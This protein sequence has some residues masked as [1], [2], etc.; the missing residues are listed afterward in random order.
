M[1]LSGVCL[2]LDLSLM[3]TLL[4]QLLLMII[5]LLLRRHGRRMQRLSRPQRLAHDALRDR[6]SMH[7]VRTHL[8]R[9]GT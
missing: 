7:W 3:L 9:S 2:S 5:R 1:R 4:Q 6:H 8:L